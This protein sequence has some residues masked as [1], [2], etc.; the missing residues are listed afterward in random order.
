MSSDGFKLG[1]PRAQR[2][3][4]LLDTLAFGLLQAPVKI[5]RHAKIFMEN[6][7][8]LLGCQWTI[9]ALSFDSKAENKCQ[10]FMKKLARH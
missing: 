3:Y 1:I 7:I 4:E 6:I 10:R 2:Y 9:R 5:K 8:L